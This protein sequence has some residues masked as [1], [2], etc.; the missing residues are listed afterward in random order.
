MDKFLS[1]K[2]VAF[3]LTMVVTPILVKWGVPEDTVNWLIATAMAYL[4]AQG[5]VDVATVRATSPSVSVTRT[6]EE[7]K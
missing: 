3:L 4:G 7:K 1:K 2:L 5:I 6:V